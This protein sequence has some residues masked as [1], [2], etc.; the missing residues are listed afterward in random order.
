MRKRKI[1]TR[2]IAVRKITVRKIASRNITAFAIALASFLFCTAAHA[3][4][5][6]PPVS[7]TMNG[8]HELRITDRDMP[9]PVRQID[10]VRL[11]KDALAL[12]TAAGSIPADI[13]SV[14]KGMLPKEIIL[15]LKQIE[16]LSKQL[17]NE[18]N[19]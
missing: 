17:R 6:H 12:A 16:K 19:P 14:R 7:P 13:E 5:G 1:A 8:S 3:Q 4:I 10:P 2:K 9:T 11:Q 15:K 18:L